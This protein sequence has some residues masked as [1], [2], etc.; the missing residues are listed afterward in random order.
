M[1]AMVFQGPNRR[2]VVE[3]P[4][5][6]VEHNKDAVVRMTK[7]TICGSDLHI[8]LGDTPET[9]AGLTLGHE[10]IGIV[11]E[12]G[13]GVYNFK[14]GDK[15]IVSC[16]TSCGTC[17]NCRRN[18]Y[19]H[20]ENGGWILGHTIDGT[21]AEYVRV[22]YADTSLYHLPDDFNEE[23]A[24][25]LS[26]ILPTGYEIGV[27]NGAVS[28]GQTVAI[29]GAGP[30]GMSALLTAQFN[31][32]SRIIQ[33]DLSES[34]LQKALDMGATD[35]VNS[36]DADRAVE[37]I[38]E[39]TGGQGVD[40]VIEAV[41]IPATFELCQRLVKPGGRIANIGVHGKPVQLHLEDLWIKNVN[42][43][44]GLV[45]AYTTQMLMRVV[46]SGKIDPTKLVTHRFSFSDV[47]QAYETFSKSAEHE[48]MK[49]IINFD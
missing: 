46:A 12:V 5:P 35:I 30:V 37:Q 38:K 2:E 4:T 8:L 25:T 34:R 11:E 21:Q 1:K 10:G 23:A 31:S 7:T 43:S 49:V 41:G 28:A 17:E 13:S 29:V 44:T 26:D 16:I 3:K 36:A 9:P 22:P 6:K 39:M 45:S 15:V 33:I 42:I 47:E 40:V 32:P 27:I 18:L 20:C 24:V 14:P 19:A 48:A